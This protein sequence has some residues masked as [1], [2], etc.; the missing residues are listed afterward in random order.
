MM[1]S[2][3]SFAKYP[4]LLKEWHPAKNGVLNPEYLSWG[5]GKKVWWKCSKGEDHEWEAAIHHR[6]SNNSGCPF[7]SDNKVSKANN[8]VVNFP[9]LAREWHPSKNGNL[10]PYDIM[11]K[12]SKRYWLLCHNKH[13]WQATVGKRTTRGQSCP[14][15][16]KIDND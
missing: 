4:H 2:K 1:I 9:E 12:I 10:T 13:S 11:P 8:F 16:T 15:C 6:A 3:Y 7:C 14:H 5:S